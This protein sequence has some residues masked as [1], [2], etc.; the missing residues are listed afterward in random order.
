[1]LR[2]RT[3][4]GPRAAANAADLRLRGASA[5]AKAALPVEVGEAAV[6]AAVAAATT[7]RGQGAGA[8]YRWA[9]IDR[10]KAFPHEIRLRLQ[11]HG[12]CAHQ[13]YP[14]PKVTTECLCKQAPLHAP[15]WTRLDQGGR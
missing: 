2:W 5:R 10:K 14:R 15:L 13:A 4:R 11:G 3:P 12:D 1:L 6:A 9:G 7:G 8:L